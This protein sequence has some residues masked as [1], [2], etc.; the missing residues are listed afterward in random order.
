MYRTI[1]ID[2]EE[3]A[4]N[5]LRE[6]LGK[7]QD[8]INV[9]AEAENG[10]EA[11]DKIDSLKP[12]LVFLDI[13]MPGL[14]GLDL[15]RKVSHQP[16]IIFATAYDEYA[17]EAFTTN[18]I[19]YLLKPIQQE[20][21]DRAVAKLQ[22]LTFDTERIKKLFEYLQTKLEKNYLTRLTC[23]IGDSIHLIN[24]NHIVYIQSKDKYTM[25]STE[26]GDF[27]IEIPLFELEEKLD[28]EKFIRI[29]R[30][31]IINYAYIEK[32]TKDDDGAL[33][34]HLLDKNHTRLQVSRSYVHKLRSL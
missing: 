9:I 30:G 12:D 25:L 13:K 10:L 33:K 32:M 28:P 5:G 27:P 16:I 24:V 23:R 15:L 34:V 17:I 22:N 31:T 4:R 26:K 29:H 19:E 20:H 11:L 3:S 14:N 18:S 2:D 7:H 1:I 6:L 8:A 21:V